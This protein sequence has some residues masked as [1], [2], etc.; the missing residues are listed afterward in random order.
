MKEHKCEY[1]ECNNLTNNPRYCSKSCSA[2]M[3]NKLHPRTGYRKT[4]QRK[5]KRNECENITPISRKYC[6]DECRKLEK[7]NRE[8]KRW[9]DRKK[10]SPSEQV[11]DYRKRQ[12]ILAV[13]YKGGKCIICSYNKYVGALHFHH[14]EPSEK[15]FSIAS[16][17]KTIPFE[18]MKNELDKCVLVCGNC[19]SEIHAGL[20]D[21]SNYL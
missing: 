3:G 14:L 21:I 15:D 7:N 12:K 8:K 17:G 11:V 2:K 4:T 19:H 20:I 6:S 16:A 18:K 10:L 13:E 5:C 9:Q 1:E